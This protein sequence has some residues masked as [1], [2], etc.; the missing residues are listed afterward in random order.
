LF[1]AVVYAFLICMMHHFVSPLSVCACISTSSSLNTVT[2]FPSLTSIVCACDG[3]MYH[4]LLVLTRDRFI[5]M[6]LST[7]FLLLS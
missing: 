1:I 5:C 4:H 3:R 7:V 6:R 2:N